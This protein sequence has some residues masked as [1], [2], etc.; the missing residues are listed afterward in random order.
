MLLAPEK[1]VGDQKSGPG[2][3]SVSRSEIGKKFL[4]TYRKQSGVIQPPEQRH[5]R[6]QAGIS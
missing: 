6:V 1:I 5:Y 4:A 3:R 2:I